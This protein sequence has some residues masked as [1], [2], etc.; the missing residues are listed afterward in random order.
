M[1]RCCGS[2]AII[3]LARDVLR[4]GLELHPDHIPGNIVLGRC[5]LDLREDG[6]AEAA[7]THV[8]DLDPENVIALKA[9]AE[10]TER[11]GRLMEARGW[12]SRLIA[13]DPSNDEARDQLDAGGLGPGGGCRR[14]HLAA[15]GSGGSPNRALPPPRRRRRS[16][17]WPGPLPR[18]RATMAEVATGEVSD[19]GDDVDGAV[20]AALDAFGAPSGRRSSR[21]RKSIRFRSCPWWPGSRP[22]SPIWNRW[23]ST[24]PPLAGE[25]TAE[26]VAGFEPDIRFAPPPPAPPSRPRS[27]RSGSRSRC[28]SISGGRVDR[29]PDAGRQRRSAQYLGGQ[30]R[31]PGAG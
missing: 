21:P 23:N 20:D 13:V 24:L 1:P 6:P 18:S 10:I 8:L 4:Q 26:P 30:V 31:V 19:H 2:T 29:V 27:S 9:L 28:R 22:R 15:H 7:F 5:C 14:D 12:L 3:L 11:Q 17:S 16:R 25:L